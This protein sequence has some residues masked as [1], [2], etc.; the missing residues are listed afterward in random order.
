MCFSND[1]E[2][3]SRRGAYLPN[4]GWWYNCLLCSLPTYNDNF[5]CNTCKR[6]RKIKEKNKKIKST[7]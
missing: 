6:N 1:Y 7:K 2:K 5:I 4:Y 3:I